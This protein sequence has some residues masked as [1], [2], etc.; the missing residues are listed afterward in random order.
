MAMNC[1]NCGAKLLDGASFCER[2]GLQL[3]IPLFKSSQ[4]QPQPTKDNKVLWIVAIVVIV[5]VV[6]PIVLSAVLYFM[7]V[8]FSGT[9]TQTPTAQMVKSSTA[10]GLR[11]T[12]AGITKDTQWGDVRILLQDETTTDSWTPTTA[13][14]TGFAGK[15]YNGGAQAIGGGKNVYLNVTDLVGNGYING[16]DYISCEPGTAFSASSTYT[17]TL[18]YAPTGSEMTHS[19]YTG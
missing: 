10:T 11:F 9:G 12:L 15:T 6:V 18:I 8:G 14:L 17:L 7:V 4:L 5:V 13:G 19:T 16:G 3:G 2:C 1:P